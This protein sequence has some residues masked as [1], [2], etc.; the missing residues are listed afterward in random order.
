[1]R[2]LPSHSEARLSVS[3]GPSLSSLPQIDR[4]LGLTLSSSPTLNK[5]FSSCLNSEIFS[6]DPI[7][8]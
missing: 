1:M 7:S 5:V 8:S 4:P 3:P 6:R 2:T